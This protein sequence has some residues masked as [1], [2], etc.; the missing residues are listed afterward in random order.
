MATLKPAPI[1]PDITRSG[2]SRTGRPGLRKKP[3]RKFGPKLYRL[4]KAPET[5]QGPGE[6]PV[7]FVNGKTSKSEW[8]PYW[9]MCKIWD[10]PTNPRV[11]PFEGDHGGIWGY[12]VYFPILGST[13]KT[14]ID[15]VYYGA[16]YVIGIRVQSEKHH[17]MTD[18]LQYQLDEWLGSHN[19]GVSAIIDVFE[20]EYLM[21]PT[22]QAVCRAMANA[23]RGIQSQSPLAKGNVF[24]IRRPQ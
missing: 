16:G 10:V 18:P 24:R 17:L 11:G 9:A 23:C 3:F 2:I 13:G 7:E 5:N 8:Y 14:N 19:F 1:Q 20:H 6:P 21:D 12:Q 22:G 15:F 4:D